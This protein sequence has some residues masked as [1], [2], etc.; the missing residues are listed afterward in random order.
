MCNKKF[1][2]QLVTYSY[3]KLVSEAENSLG[4]QTKGMFAVEIR[5]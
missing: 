2:E 1:C 5:Y 4:I 3:M